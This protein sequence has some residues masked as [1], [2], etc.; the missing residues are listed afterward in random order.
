M[1][2]VKNNQYLEPPTL[3][4]GTPESNIFFFPYCLGSLACLTNLALN[5]VFVHL[6]GRYRASS[7]QSLLRYEDVGPAVNISAIE[8]LPRPHKLTSLAEST[9]V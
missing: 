3:I 6:F 9:L 1:W 4:G 2:R 7:K 5:D 8:S